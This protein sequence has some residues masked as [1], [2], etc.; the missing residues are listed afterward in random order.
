MKTYKVEIRTEVHMTKQEYATYLRE[1]QGSLI[2]LIQHEIKKRD[3]A[4]ERCDKQVLKF[5]K[6]IDELESEIETL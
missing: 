5:Q 4:Q 6:R 2:K 3:A 1:R